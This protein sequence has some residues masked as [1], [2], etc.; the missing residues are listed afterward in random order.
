MPE[1]GDKGEGVIGFIMPLVSCGDGVHASIVFCRKSKIM[2]G[3]VHTC[4]P[5]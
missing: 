4:L 2:F 1:V 3:V 5:S